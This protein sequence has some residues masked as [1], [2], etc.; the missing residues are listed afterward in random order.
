M[1]KLFIVLFGF[2]VVV[3]CSLSAKYFVFDAYMDK[4]CEL[5]FALVFPSKC[6][7]RSVKV[8]AWVGWVGGNM[9]RV[10][11]GPWQEGPGQAPIE[12]ALGISRD[13]LT[14]FVGDDLD[15]LGDYIRIV[16]TV[17]VRRLTEPEVYYFSEVLEVERLFFDEKK[18]RMDLEEFMYSL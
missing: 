13:K 18:H 7:G 15:Y 6:V 14:G 3:I 2:V 9:V 8:T 16:G 4:K 17:E 11:V 1:R 12:N 10:Y 5:E